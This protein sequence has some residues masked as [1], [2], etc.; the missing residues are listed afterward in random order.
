L[1]LVLVAVDRTTSNWRVRPHSTHAA[2]TTTA[3]W[4]YA[5][6]GGRTVDGDHALRTWTGGLRSW[7]QRSTSDASL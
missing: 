2:A 3:S 7:P 6:W 5:G 4:S 1:A